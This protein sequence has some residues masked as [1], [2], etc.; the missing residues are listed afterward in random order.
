MKKLFTNLKEKLNMSTEELIVL[1]LLILSWIANFCLSILLFKILIEKHIWRW[2][3][4]FLN[5]AISMTLSLTQN[6]VFGN[7]RKH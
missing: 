4:M 5:M 7:R 1:I 2:D 3:I 6:T